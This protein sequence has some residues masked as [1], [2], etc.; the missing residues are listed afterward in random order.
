MTGWL[1]IHR[2]WRECDVFG[3]DPCS[4]REAWLWLIEN[5]A[6]KPCHRRA[7]KGDMVKLE[8]G[9][10]HTAERTLAAIWKWDRK[11]VVRFL[12]RLE[13]CEM[14]SQR[15]DHS[16]H[17]VTVCNYAK[18]QDVEASTGTIHGAD[19]GAD[20]GPIEDHRGTTQEEGK[21]GK[22]KIEARGTRLPADFQVP[23]EWI[24][25]AMDRKRWT[26]T[27]ATSEAERFCRHFQTKAGKDAA[28][29]DWFK[30]W[31]NWCTGPYAKPDGEGPSASRPLTIEELKRAIRR[32]ED[33]NDPD[34]AA[35]LKAMLAERQSTGPPPAIQS[36]IHRTASN[37]SAGPH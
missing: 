18:Y 23:E 19:K 3:D 13:K 7:G 21:E 31:Q 29:L 12:T 4:D 11:R 20:A 5:A 34:R 24:A 1:R 30:T 14:I 9:Q 37:L 8:R 16:G 28:K 33:F 6:W 15:K 2:G 26:R 10:L 22:R 35:E 17:I 27:V 25:W 36:I 32:A